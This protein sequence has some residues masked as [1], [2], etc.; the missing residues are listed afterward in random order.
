MVQQTSL[1]VAE[2]Q[3][4]R[5]AIS[6]IGRVMRSV[7]DL[8]ICMGKGEILGSAISK[9]Q[10]SS[11]LESL[12]RDLR[13]FKSALASK[14]RYAGTIAEIEMTCQTIPEVYEEFHGKKKGEGHERGRRKKRRK[15]LR[16]SL[17]FHLEDKVMIMGKSD[18]EWLR[19]YMS[20]SEVLAR[21]E[22]I[23]EDYRQAEREAQEHLKFQSSLLFNAALFMGFA[24]TVLVAFLLYHIF[25]SGVVTRLRM[26]NKTLDDI[27]DGKPLQER[28]SVEAESAH[29]EVGY[30]ASEL[31]SMERSLRSIRSKEKTLLENAASCICSIDEQGRFVKVS[32]ASTFLWGVAPDELLGTSLSDLIET[33]DIDDVQGKLEE[34]FRTRQPV[35]FTCRVRTPEGDSI[36]FAWTASLAAEQ[37]LAVCVAH[38]VTKRNEILRQ[39]KQREIEFRSMVD[40][41]PIALITCDQSNAIS[42]IN[43]ATQ[44]MLEYSPQELLGKKLSMLLF[45]G[46]KSG[47]ATNEQMNEVL[48]TAEKHTIELLVSKADGS[49]LPVEFSSSHYELYDSRVRLATFKD[50]SAR[51]EIE[52][53]KKELV[54]MISHDLRSPL[55][56]IHCTLELIGFD[57]TDGADRLSEEDLKNAKNVARAE[58]IVFSIVN[59][60]NDFLDLEKFQAGLVELE[61]EDVTVSDLIGSLS[62][63]L[64]SRDEPVKFSVDEDGDI[65]KTLVKIDSSRVL[66]ALSTIFLVIDCFSEGPLDI[67]MARSDDQIRMVIKSNNIPEHIENAFLSPYVFLSD[68]ELTGVVA[69]GLSLS[70]SRAILASHGGFVRIERIN[71]GFH[72]EIA[73][74]RA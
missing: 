54:A 15:R 38:D 19:V 50:V 52:T 67:A 61:L 1:Q 48:S 13:A 55:T 47:V 10:Y 4:A 33:T 18:I 16:G 42:S 66:F 72:I 20:A 23:Q 5:R 71:G 60:L 17:K 44:K 74:P 63:D 22:A 64:G 28:A 56:A 59:V 40:C 27:A 68:T 32:Q 58:K 41:M 62:E 37:N 9:V 21:L 30:L 2:Q 14:P 43:P 3:E 51:F 25:I 45:G 53:G 39:I 36:E 29:D 31:Q 49:R 70:L 24:A 57:D 8:I 73:L 34:L 11:H 26:I 7:Q 35:T 46:T 65:L 12:N 69:S 6:S